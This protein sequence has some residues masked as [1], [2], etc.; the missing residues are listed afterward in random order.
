[1]VPHP[2]F[3]LDRGATV[4]QLHCNFEHTMLSLNQQL[5]ER[6]KS[7]MFKRNYFFLFVNFL[8]LPVGL[9]SHNNCIRRTMNITRLCFSWRNSRSFII[10]TLNTIKMQKS[11]Q[12]FLFR[13][14]QCFFFIRL[15][16]FSKQNAR[17][18]I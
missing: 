4:L 9:I 17:K 3:F 7:F 8:I 2:D 18:P 16:C 6:K 12:H 13:I 11:L 15:H 10:Y 1:M 5:L 14:Q